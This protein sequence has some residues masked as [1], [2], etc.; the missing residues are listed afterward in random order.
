MRNGKKK[1]SIGGLIYMDYYS[2]RKYVRNTI[3]ISLFLAVGVMLVY[4]SFQVGNLRLLPEDVK[5]E[6]MKMAIGWGKYLPIYGFCSIP[7]SVMELSV[8]META[9]WNRFRLTT[10]AGGFRFALAKVLYMMLL[11]AVAIGLSVTYLTIYGMIFPG[12]LNL[13][14]FGVVFLFMAG[15]N[16]M[17]DMVLIYGTFFQSIEKAALALVGTFLIL[18]V[19]FLLISPYILPETIDTQFDVFGFLESHGTQLLPGSLA[20]LV[21]TYVVCFLAVGFMYQR[22]E[23]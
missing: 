17:G 3:L 11:M 4:A 12:Q 10:P 15:V 18:L 16:L 14:T 6:A 23:K 9:K 13:G 22:R 1:A 8:K 5:E 2:G 21:L 7:E 19:G 20:V